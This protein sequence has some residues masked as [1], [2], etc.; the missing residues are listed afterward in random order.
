MSR[1]YEDEIP[2]RRSSASQH[3]DLHHSVGQLMAESLNHRHRLETL[4]TA[5]L[6]KETAGSVP[7]SG[8]E[9]LV[10]ARKTLTTTLIILAALVSALKELGFLK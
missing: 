5:L 4:E 2:T 3:S 10:L 8:K 6:H 1:Y 7:P 9:L